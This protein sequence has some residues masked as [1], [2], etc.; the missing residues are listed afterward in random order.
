MRALRK[1]YGRAR[2]AGWMLATKRTPAHDR[3]A[4]AAFRKAKKE[5][6]WLASAWTKAMTRAAGYGGVVPTAAERETA[7]AY[8]AKL[9]EESKVHAEIMAAARRYA[10]LPKA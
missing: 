6:A 8:A 5:E 4:D 2:V 3:A 9:A 10:Q 7:A 1:R